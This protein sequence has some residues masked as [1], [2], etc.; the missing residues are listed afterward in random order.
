MEKL[1]AVVIDDEYLNRDLIT[2]LV[3]RIDSN[4]QIIGEAENIDKGFDLIKS[5]NPD[6]IFLDIKMP[7][8]NGSNY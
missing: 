2:K 6:L 3:K 8:G 1:T 5:K 4:F 7:G